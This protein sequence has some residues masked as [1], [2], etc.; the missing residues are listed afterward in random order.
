MLEAVAGAMLAA[1]ESL[2]AEFA[3]LHRRMLWGS[4]A[5]TRSAGG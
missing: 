3:R 1:R 5:P 4:R 2:L